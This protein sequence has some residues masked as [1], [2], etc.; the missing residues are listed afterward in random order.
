MLNYLRIL[1]RY[2]MRALF[3]KRFNFRLKN[4]DSFLSMKSRFDYDYIE[5]VQIGRDVLIS[6][7]CLI[8]VCNRD[9]NNR[10]SRLIIGESSFIGEFN[11]I[12]A[13]GGEIKIGQYC[14]ISQHC[15]LVASNHLTKRGV[16]ISQQEWDEEKTGIEIGDDVWIGAN[17]C[18]LPG[19]KI[20]NGAVIGAGSVI[21]RDIPDNAIAVGNPARVIKYRE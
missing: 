7:W 19:V 14:N 5:D 21:T 11:N 3:D 9:K 4:I 15:S 20:G 18:V 13:T 10:I 17:S 6:D 1:K 12:R 8:G 16:N 2:G